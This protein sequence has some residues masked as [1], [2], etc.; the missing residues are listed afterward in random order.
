MPALAF[1]AFLLAL[2]AALGLYGRRQPGLLG[3]RG[4]SLVL[5]LLMAWNPGVPWARTRHLQPVVVVDASRSMGQA[6][7]WPQV[8]KVLQQR[9]AG[10]PLRV[11]FLVDTDL[12]ARVD[13]PVGR[14]TDLSVP[15][16]R[17]RAPIVLLSDGLHNTGPAPLDQPFPYPVSVW[18][19]RV[20]AGAS[21]LGGLN[22]EA[23]L[24]LLEQQPFT[25]ALR[26]ASPPQAGT[27]QV[28]I[29]DSLLGRFFVP[30]G[31]SW[32]QA[33]SVAGLPAGSHRVQVRWGRFQKSRALQVDPVPFQALVRVYRPLPIVRHLRHTLEGF[34][35]VEVVLKT[36]QGWRRLGETPRA[37]PAPADPE[38]YTVVVEIA[39]PAPESLSVPQVIVAGPEQPRGLALQAGPWWYPNRPDLPP[40]DYLRGPARGTPLLQVKG[41]RGTLQPVAVIAGRRLWLLSGQAWRWAL[42]SPTL[43]DSLWGR[44]LGRLLAGRV[45]FRAWIQPRVAAPGSPITV[46][47]LLTDLRGRRVPGAWV[48]VQNGPE[49]LELDPGRFS[50]RLRAADSLGLH[51]I[52]LV[53]GAG[54]DTL[55]RKTLK[56][57][58]KPLD[59]ETL[60]QG[61]DS[62]LLAEL[63]RR[64]GGRVLP[65]TGPVTLQPYGERQTRK[66][67]FARSPWLLLALL[68]S[69]FLEWLLR[70]R[71]GWL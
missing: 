46:E 69:L 26:W 70:Q 57:R 56:Y 45:L 59:L 7:K 24:R 23:P 68:I 36:P 13:S 60:T 50:G 31:A 40:L 21:P 52:R 25:V 54:A 30:A 14:F 28:F 71:R 6:D 65:P 27:L 16:R 35:R 18:W 3:L 11:V 32:Q 48:R 33:L 39:P 55:G 64:T 43:W 63:A 34:G 22:L 47:A 12:V 17:L 58:V 29:D 51:R 66:L 37:G 41:R 2:M 8:Q 20:A 19:P 44:W 4:L 15:L 9:L 38:N 53:Y 5:L 67:H 10:H 61:V 1:L 49:L 62:L 42:A